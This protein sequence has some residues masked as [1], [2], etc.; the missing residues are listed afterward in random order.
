M[1]ISDK[2]LSHGSAGTFDLIDPS[3]GLR[4]TEV[5]MGGP[6]EAGKAVAAASA[7]A[8]AWRRFPPH[9]RRDLLLRLADL[10]S[11]NRDL[12]GT[13]A[14]VEQGLP[15]G[16][17]YARHC[18]EWVRYYAGWSEKIHGTV[19]P[20]YPV[21][22]LAYVVK[23]PYGVVAVITP[24]NESLSALGMKVAPA[25]AAGNCV[26]V[27]P[28]EQ[29]PLQTT[30]FARLALEAGIPPGVLNVITGGPAAGEALVRHA[31]VRKVSFT[32]GIRTA[33]AILK[34][35]AE[36]VTPVVTEL[37][38]KSAN[39]VFADGD[40]QAGARLSAMNACVNIA[41]QGCMFPTRL[42]VEES[43]H[44]A[45]VEEVRRLLAPVTIGDPADD[46]TEMGP[47]I[48]R[49]A[50]DRIMGVI[51]RAATHSKL[52]VGG[53]R[54]GGD[55]ADGF[56][57]EP[58]VFDDVDPDSELAREEVF[59]PVLAITSFR[60]DAEAVA[61]ANGSEAGLAAYLYTDNLRRAHSIAREL[62]AG[63]VGING[64]TT[65]PPTFPFGGY[66][67]SGVG[68]EGGQDGLLEFLQTKTVYVPLGEA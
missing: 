36:T 30:L 60:D 39:I 8:P 64:M 38:G 35:A 2:W 27:K 58:T 52:I 21:D 12:F 18:A 26:V 45:V 13:V 61:I 50:M 54:R 48:D 1:L 49:T 7:A 28:P 59:G 11:A 33:R 4:V 66:K 55:L 56:F 23:E 25:L 57:I 22:A 47:V 67:Q 53:K 46:A 24:F 65:V 63:T 14:A 31:D 19:N 5:P 41:G 62:E 6:N 37:G 40:W 44:D 34:A 10:I 29:T 3:T 20:S 15:G 17:I 51:E 42:L 32:G 43:V 9:K 16:S 68:R